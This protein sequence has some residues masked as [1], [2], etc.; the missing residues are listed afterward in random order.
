[1]KKRKVDLEGARAFAKRGVEDLLKELRKIEAILPVE[2]FE[3]HEHLTTLLALHAMHP[4]LDPHLQED[5]GIYQLRRAWIQGLAW[6]GSIP[7]LSPYEAKIESLVAASATSRVAY[8]ALCHHSANLCSSCCVII[9]QLRLFMVEVLR[10]ERERPSRRGTPKVHPS[11][12]QIL[13]ALLVDIVDRFDVSPT[14]N[15]ATPSGIS[16]CD[17][18]AEAMPNDPRLPKSQSA[19]EQIWLEGPRNEEVFAERMTK[20]IEEGH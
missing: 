9:P 2:D 13:Y 17:I 20:L 8:E 6:P 14:R 7:K 3:L 16:A 12:N 1:M 4:L 15:K 5:L 19:L 10:G 18:V 11:R